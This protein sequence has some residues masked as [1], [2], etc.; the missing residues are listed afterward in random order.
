ML[1]IGNSEY[2]WNGD[3]LP[4]RIEA[5]ADAVNI[6][7]QPKF[8]SN[9]GSTVGIITIAR[10]EYVSFHLWYLFMPW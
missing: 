7:F 8:D 4:T 6:V 2:M 5:Q 3:Y 9:A 1:I 10:K